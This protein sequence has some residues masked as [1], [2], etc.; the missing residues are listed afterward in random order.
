MHDMKQRLFTVLLPVHRPPLLLPFSTDTVLKQELADFEL[1]IICDGAPAETGKWA[2]QMEKQDSRI[3][4]FINGKGERHGEAWRHA[5]LLQA[6]GRYVAHINDDDLWFPNHLTEMEALLRNA[7][8]GN[9][10]HVNVSSSGEPRCIFA[11]LGDEQVRRHMLDTRFNI[12]GPT[13][14]GYTLEAYKR[15]HGGWSPAPPYLYSDL[16]M[17]RKFLTTPGLKFATRFAVTSLHFP[18]AEFRFPDPAVTEE[19]LACKLSEMGEWRRRIADSAERDLIV[20]SVFRTLCARQAEMVKN[21]LLVKIIHY[22]SR[23]LPQAFR[24]LKRFLSK[25]FTSQ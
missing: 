6:H 15:L 25:I 12:F 17:W 3:H 20:Q 1:F 4:A 21:R 19:E 24:R 14:A 10:L 23:K 2:K 7:D 8:F 18:D 11:D 9:L 16:H 5:A 22:G 13:V